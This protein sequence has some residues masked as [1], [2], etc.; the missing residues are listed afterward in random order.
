MS[1][2]RIYIDPSGN[3]ACSVIA[4]TTCD[5]D[6]DIMVVRSDGT[7]QCSSSVSK[8]A[9]SVGSTKSRAKRTMGVLV[10]PEL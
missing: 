2:K 10:N 1:S 3:T 4:Y 5:H 9:I 7:L 8:V 6:V